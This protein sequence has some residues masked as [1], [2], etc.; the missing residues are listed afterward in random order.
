MNER[1]I[2]KLKTLYGGRQ[3]VDNFG[4]RPATPAEIHAA[5]KRDNWSLME[6]TY[7]PTDKDIKEKGD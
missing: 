3:E 1:F 5:L 4:R 2:R 7:L 6:A